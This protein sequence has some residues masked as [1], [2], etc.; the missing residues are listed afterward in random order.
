MQ[1]AKFDTFSRLIAYKEAPFLQIRLTQK[2]ERSYESHSHKTLSV[3]YILEG[4][5][6]FQTPKGNFLLESGALAII[7]P[8]MQHAC[9]PLPN[10]QR[11]YVMVYVD[12]AFCAD[13]L[14]APHLGAFKN[15]LILHKK[16][17]E[18]FRR[19]IG[20]LLE[21]YDALH[22]R[23]LIDW[24]KRFLTLYTEP[25]KPSFPSKLHEVAWFLENRFDEETTLPSLAKRFGYNPYVLLRRFKQTYGCTP[26][27]YACDMRIHHAKTLLQEGMPSA[28]CAQYCGFVDQS[29]FHRFFKRRTALTPKEYQ[30]SFIGSEVPR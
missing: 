2:S 10:T 12:A 16:L 7:E 17:S 22:V 26:K 24:L 28:L 29:H 11:S 19:I 3:G 9:N 6:V 20:M 8:F 21:G 23:L 15:T 27:H 13:V 1:R 30:R 4:K 18:E 5:T 25:S 14:N